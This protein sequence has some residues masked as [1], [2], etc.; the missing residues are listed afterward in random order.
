[1]LFMCAVQQRPA[2]QDKCT[3]HCQPVALLLSESLLPAACLLICTPQSATAERE[4]L[5]DAAKAEAAAQLQAAH[6]AAEVAAAALAEAKAVATAEA[7]RLAADKTELDRQL[8]VA[9]VGVIR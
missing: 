8:K 6:E 4:A 3:S 7:G 5:L 1:M 9:Q 2:F